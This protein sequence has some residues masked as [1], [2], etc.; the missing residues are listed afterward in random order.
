MTVDEVQAIVGIE[1]TKL[2]A[3]YGEGMFWPRLE[4]S[5]PGFAKG[6]ALAALISNL[7]CGAPSLMGID[8]RD[9][10][11]KTTT[12]LGIGSTLADIKKRYPKARIQNFNADGFP[13]AISVEP[14]ISFAFQNATESRDTERVTMLW[15]V[16]QTDVKSRR[17]PDER[18]A[19]EVYQAVFDKIVKAGQRDAA[20]T[21]P[22]VIVLSE[23]VHLCDAAPLRPL[24]HV[25]CLERERMRA[26]FLEGALAESFFG[27][28]SGRWSI[29]MPEGASALVA[30]SDIDR[31]APLDAQG[32]FFRVVFSRPGFAA[33]R[34]VVYVSYIC[35]NSCGAGTLIELEFRDSKW[36]IIAEQPLWV[37][38]PSPT[39]PQ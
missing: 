25:G 20:S 17:C 12:G 34:A 22:P 4:I 8:V 7:P 24:P 27:R 31:V 9:P 14:G 3:T 5:L 29:P 36:Q 1:H 26:P 21:A 35:G 32:R 18:D 30:P 6:P 37:S 33:G 2:V 39:E 13:V 15:V 16:P 19:R 23:S 38:A 11:F 10:R 28:N